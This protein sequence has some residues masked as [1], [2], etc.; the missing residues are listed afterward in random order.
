MR[1][2]LLTMGGLEENFGPR[3]QVSRPLPRTSTICD[4]FPEPWLHMP[5]PA[6]FPKL[7]TPPPLLE[8]L[9]NFLYNIITIRK[10]KKLWIF[11]KH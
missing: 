8:N 2:A 6:R 10:D 9:K 1:S 5:L 4:F 3:P 7:G 11:M